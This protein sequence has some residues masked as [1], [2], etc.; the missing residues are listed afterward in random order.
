MRKFTLLLVWSV[1]IC[2]YSTAQISTFPYSEDFE[3]GAGGWA[4]A[5]TGSWALGTPANTIINSA[6]SGTNAWVTN[7]TGTYNS[8]EA[9][10]VESP[11][12][13][14]TAVT[15]PYIQAQVW[16]NAEFSWDG[17]VLQS[18]IDNKV[19]WQ[20]VGT[21]GD[22][23]NW[24]T[25]NSIN[26]APGGSQEG[27][28][29][30][31]SS[32]NGSGGWVPAQHD[33]MSLAGQPSV[34]LRFAF[35]SDGSVQ[36]EGVAF[37]DIYIVNITCPQPST[38]DTANVTTTDVDF[39]WTETGGATTWNILVVPAG[40]GP[41][42]PPTFA[43]VTSNPFTITGL[44]PATS[45][46][47][48]VQSDCG[49]GDL[50]FWSGPISIF[51]DCATLTPSWLDNVEGHALNTQVV[52][53]NC[54]TGTFTGSYDWN[55]QSGPTSSSST[56]PNAAHSGSKYFYTEASGGTT[57]AQAT[58]VTPMIDFTSMTLPMLKF[59]YHMYGSSMGSL[60]VEYW[61]GAMWVQADSI[62]GQQQ[63]SGADPWIER[64]VYLPSLV[65]TISQV[66]FVGT[67]GSN[68]YSDMSIDD[69]SITEAPPCTAPYAY[70][71]TTPVDSLLSTWSY[72][73]GALAVTGFDIEYGPSGYAY[74]T[75][76]MVN[77]DANYSDTTYDATFLPGA[78]YDVYLQAICGTDSS[79]LVGP[80]PITTALTNDTVCGAAQL[81][82]D[83]TVYTFNGA[84]ATA[85]AGE[86]AIAPP[87][88]GCSTN[89]GWCNSTVSASTW[90]TFDA[91]ASGN[92]NISGLDV[93]FD[94]QVAVYEVTDCGN[95]TTFTLIGANDDDFDTGLSLAP[96]VTLCGL[97]PG[98]TYYLMHDPWSTSST[99]IYSL[100]LTEVS[101][102][103]GTDAGMTTV[104]V[105][106]TINLDNQITG[107]DAG[108]TWTGLTTSAGLS[109]STFDSDGLAYQV[110][111]FQYTVTQSCAMDSVLTQVQIYGPSSAGI[112]GVLDVCK[113]QPINLLA[114][115][116]GNVDLG[117]TW[118]DPQN[119]PTSSSIIASSFSGQYNFDYI[120]GNGICPDD[121]SNV[122]VNV[123]NTCD[124]LAI[125]EL[126]FGN[127]EMYPNPTT[128]VLFITNIGSAE[129]F[130]YEVTDLNG[131]VI[132][133]GK[134]AISATETT[135][136]NLGKLDPGMYLIRVFNEN[137]DKTYRVVKE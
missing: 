137:A 135:E 133:I 64:T 56:G 18:S 63:T 7:L 113:N 60:E 91:P 117:G 35:G 84:G 30:R 125:E 3:S 73:P 119:N 4:A 19:S 123:L 114:G 92:V 75:G 52:S 26:G 134:D 33:M 8:N 108:G 136:V 55:V 54:W 85:D 61:D 21:F 28:T 14:F 43:G 98:N 16:W 106:D 86:A 62:G 66:R 10:W 99:G 110:F 90:F 53:S 70:S 59:W 128:G 6:A 31:N 23:N 42:G 109:G 29:G 111:D 9:G 94:G 49:G 107:A 44:S 58:L 81:T 41:T 34:Y 47:I 11:E 124:Y 118:Y 38:L 20:N 13:D 101:V 46:D 82:V 39:S 76:T 50:S 83:G 37:D 1:G 24:Y 15:A 22:P 100:A 97:T 102:E 112:D 57:G 79:A 103:A 126:T 45:Y 67:R 5:G 32:G 104:C 95:F 131:K 27:W 74:G 129:V 130:D 116:S 48:Y 40:T 17:M 96:N 65:G 77:A 78:M 87:A 2:L 80:L 88:T 71:A 127:I 121:T 51:T 122:I 69:I 89:D 132:Y 105:G 120:T 93:G 72:Y 25:D 12:F 115:L 68:F 36:D